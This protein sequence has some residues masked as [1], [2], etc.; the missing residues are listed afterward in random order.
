MNAAPVL[1]KGRIAIANYTSGPFASNDH[2]CDRA[3]DFAS[4]FSTTS[5]SQ[6]CSILM[7]SNTETLCIIVKVFEALELGRD[8][9][10]KINHR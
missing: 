9:T 2:G 3:V 10:I 5:I 1:P 7:I 4:S 6:G 8:I